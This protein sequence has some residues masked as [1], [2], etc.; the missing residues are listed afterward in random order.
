MFGNKACG[1]QYQIYLIL[2][3]LVNSLLSSE[4][5]YLFFEYLLLINY[6]GWIT[7]AYT[8]CV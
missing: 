1:R 2:F 5:G 4:D 3:G 6:M 8:I 7:V